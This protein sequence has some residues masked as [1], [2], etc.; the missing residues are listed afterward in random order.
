VELARKDRWPYVKLAPFYSNERGADDQSVVG[1]G[2]A[3]P[4][5]L[6]DSKKAS[7]EQAKARLQQADTS[8][9]VTQ[10]QIERQVT[11]HALAYEKQLAEMGRWRANAS[12][13]FREAA[14]LG[15]RH[16]RLGSL[17]VSTYLELQ[18]QYLDAT[19]ALLSTQADALENW[20]EVELLLGRPL[21][22]SA[23]TSGGSP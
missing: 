1:V 19:E 15:D 8:L 17:P 9:R 3:L 6:W 11:E 16:Y 14:A 21:P 2:I 5:P 4:L 13:Q 18:K 23:P 22:P 7:M 12:A 10:R 20:Q